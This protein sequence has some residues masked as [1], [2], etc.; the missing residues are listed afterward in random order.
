MK[1]KIGLWI[2]IVVSAVAA[3]WGG[4]ELSGNYKSLDYKVKFQN[5]I[6]ELYRSGASAERIAEAEMALTSFLERREPIRSPRLPLF[7]LVLG[8]AGVLDAGSR[9]R[10]RKNDRNLVRLA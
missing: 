7:A 6:I 9:L 8:C 1:V 3:V 10:S 2:L 5:N 4:L